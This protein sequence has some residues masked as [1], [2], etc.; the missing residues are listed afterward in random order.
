MI[1]N[2][3]NLNILWCV[4]NASDNSQSEDVQNDFRKDVKFS[5]N[6]DMYQALFEFGIHKQSMEFLQH[7]QQS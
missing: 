1:K 2:L 6:N 3:D 4:W 5:S 7:Q